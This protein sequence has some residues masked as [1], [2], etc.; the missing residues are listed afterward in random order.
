MLF[1]HRNDG[2][3]GTMVRFAFTPT[4][5]DRPMRT[6]LTL[7][8]AASILALANGSTL[9]A[10]P[11][12]TG[13]LGM[14]AHTGIS[15]DGSHAP[16][17]ANKPGTP[18]NPNVIRKDGTTMPLA[19]QEGGGDKNLATSQQD[20]QAQQQGDKTAAAKAEKDCTE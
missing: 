10:C 9:A 12:K 8:I 11:S 2:T 17:E 1:R 20:V 16:L 6:R 4:K 3:C 13:S 7:M 5:E 19:K 14:Q 18:A 15:K